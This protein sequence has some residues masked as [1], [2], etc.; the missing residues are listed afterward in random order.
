[1]EDDLQEASEGI[2]E[3]SVESDELDHVPSID[4]EIIIG[5][6]Q[7]DT[8]SADS[9]DE[10]DTLN[11]TQCSNSQSDNSFSN[12]TSLSMAFCKELRPDGTKK[13]TRCRYCMKLLKTREL[14]RLFD[15]ASRCSAI[16]SSIRKQIVSD[17]KDYVANKG[18]CPKLLADLLTTQMIVDLNLSFSSL[19]RPSVKQWIKAL[20]NAGSTYKLPSRRRISSKLLPQL[21]VNIESRMIR[22]LTNRQSLSAEFDFWTDKKGTRILA[23]VITRENGSR[24]L[25]GIKDTS[26]SDHSATVI[27]EDVVELLDPIDKA[28]ITCIVSD[29]EAACKRARQLIVERP[30]YKRTLQHSCFP[31]LLNRIA[32]HFGKNFDSVIRWATQLT[33]QIRS[34][35]RMLAK[36]N[37][38]SK[39]RPAR[40]CAVRW[41]SYADMMDNLIDIRE[42]LI[43]EANNCKQELRALIHDSNKWMVMKEAAVILRQIS[44]VIAEAER[45][46]CTLGEA[47]RHAINFGKVIF[48]ADLTEST[49][50]Y[51]ATSFVTYFSNKKLKEELGLML[52]AYIFDPRN[53]MRYVTNAAMNLAFRSAISIAIKLGIKSTR[54][55]KELVE[56]YSDYTMIRGD[57]AEVIRPSETVIEY[58][59]RMTDT[60]YPTI[61]RIGIKLARIF[62]SSANIERTFSTMKYIQGSWRLSMS[63]STLEHLARCKIDNDDIIADMAKDDEECQLIHEDLIDSDEEHDSATDNS[64]VSSANQSP[65]T[66]VTASEPIAGRSS[67][68]GDTGAPMQNAARFFA[69]P[70]VREL[71]VQYQSLI[72]YSNISHETTEAQNTCDENPVDVTA[73][74]MQS[75]QLRRAS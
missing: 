73:L 21:S 37:I 51:A 5:D 47:V 29:S 52:A 50:R 17:Q 66:T 8:Q 4:E 3:L 31:H 33:G 61:S 45:K 42:L 24:Y 23:V 35:S 72:D 15:H 19:E 41:Y 48:E 68:A 54:I 57:F 67:D 26:I 9:G 36:L 46:D 18:I 30:E 62:S 60:G 59:Y 65:S 32:Q 43:L 56:E 74:V 25:C 14:Q 12:I 64:R 70:S 34:N 40:P 39:R 75:E 10:R 7:D 71:V 53:K 55:E 69:D 2:S 16:E 38:A 13:D 1:M 11:S 27:A 58:W 6:H 20:L 28:S 22:S 44:N 63:I 49:I